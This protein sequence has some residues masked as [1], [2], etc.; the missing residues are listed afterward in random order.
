MTRTV[1]LVL[2][3]ALAPTARAAE[4]SYLAGAAPETAKLNEVVSFK[5]AGDWHFNLKAPQDCGSGP[6]FDVKENSLKCQF[7]SGGEQAVLLNI[8][9]KDGKTC[10]TE[11]FTVKVQGRPA[12]KRAVPPEAASGPGLE[13]FLLNA[14]AAALAQA[15]KE[16]KLLFIDFFG[17]WCPPCR[18]MEDT[19]LGQP[20]F[21]EVS[22]GMV[23]V[24]IDIDLPLAREWLARFKVRSYPTYLVAD[25]E[26]REIGRS[27]SQDFIPFLT[28]L[29]KQRSWGDSPLAAAKAAAAS[30]DEAGRLRVAEAYLSEEKWGEAA[31]LLSGIPSRYAAYL[32]AY[33]AV[34]KQAAAGEKDLAP[35]YRG[36]IERF[37]GRDGQD[38][39]GAVPDWIAELHKLDPEGA[40]PYLDDLE[41]LAARLEASKEA[42]AE[43][44]SGPS[45]PLSLAYALQKAGLGERAREYFIKTAAAYGSLAEKAGGPERAKGLRMMQCRYLGPAE[46]YGEMAAIYA[47]LTEKFP[48]EYAFHRSYAAVLLKLGKHQEALDEAVLAA[49]LSYGDIR[50]QIL[51]LKAEIELAR[52]DK[53]A[54]VRTLREALAEADLPGD[55][56]LGTH[57]AYRGLKDYLAKV[58][59]SD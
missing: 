29:K 48:S 8:C 41:G 58:E 3:F 14:P 2:L 35:L 27:G 49:G 34:K 28:W 18:L 5:P 7:S 32:A 43:G 6:A 24:G 56:T 16:K 19:V 25:T 51:R 37:D 13:G 36:L 39:M 31:A 44:V 54:A 57:G 53:A 50:L 21:L 46:K 40:K 30:L 45:I 23:R 10:V 59:A 12:A 22:S 15:K 52:K 17:K 55:R 38:A 4:R 20:E 42:A 1:T 11:E 33:A 26:L 9:D 47:G